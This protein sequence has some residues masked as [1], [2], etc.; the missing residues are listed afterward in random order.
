MSPRRSNLASVMAAVF[1]AA[2]GFAALRSGSRAWLQASYGLTLVTLLA[3]TLLG[4]T[5]RGEAGDFWFGFAL[6][7]WAYLLLGVSNLAVV[8]PGGNA[9]AEGRPNGFLPMT[10]WLDDAL[11]G[12]AVREPAGTATPLM[13]GFYKTNR[14]QRTLWIAQLQITLGFALLGGIS[15]RWL[16]RRGP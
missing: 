8:F 14:F 11:T 9:V 7:G 3:A 1:V 10:D 15:A 13:S 6:F 4:R 2:C 16:A 12:L 5:R